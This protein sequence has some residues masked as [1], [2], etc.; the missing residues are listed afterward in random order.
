MSYYPAIMYDDFSIIAKP[1]TTKCPLNGLF[2]LRGEP[3]PHLIQPLPASAGL[4]ELEPTPHRGALPKTF[5]GAPEVG[6]GPREAWAMSDAASWL[7]AS[8]TRLR[9]LDGAPCQHKG[10]AKRR[11]Q[12]LASFRNDLA[13]LQLQ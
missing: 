12:V 9:S 1:H 11:P 10:V 8:R 2:E 6:P 3:V 4:L 7:G 5:A 13:L